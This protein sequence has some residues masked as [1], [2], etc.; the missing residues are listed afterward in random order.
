[1][2]GRLMVAD[3]HCCM[4]RQIASCIASMT[5]E[6]RLHG[7]RLCCLWNPGSYIDLPLLLYD[8]NSPSCALCA[9]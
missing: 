7:N 2:H 3:A 9:F 5:S 6:S 1:M 8:T 4:P